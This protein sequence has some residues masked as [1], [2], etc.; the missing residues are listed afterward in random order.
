[1]V[2]T[3]VHTV[4][5]S[6][7]HLES[8][9]CRAELLLEVLGRY[10][11]ERLIIVGDLY[12]KGSPIGDNQFEV[13]N[14]LRENSEKIVYVNGNH[15]PAG[16]ILAGGIAGIKTV[17]EYM[18]TMGEKKF[19]S[20]HGHQFDQFLFIFSA[21][22]IDRIF[23]K[24]VALVKKTDKEKWHVSKLISYM[25]DWLSG[26]IV[27]KAKKYALKND[28]NVII[29]GH[30]HIAMHTSF[31]EIG[32]DYFNCGNWNDPNGQCSFLTIDNQGKTELHFVRDK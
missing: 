1:M 21:P 9:D 29:C 12:E 2:K 28:A 11:F 8:K 19:C 26:H 7:I 6:D 32:V 14:Y 16:E 4:A 15:D 17:D 3:Q 18:W 5:V 27:T 23:T 30:T 13:V 31:P 22:L 24:I 20:L 25:H 10:E